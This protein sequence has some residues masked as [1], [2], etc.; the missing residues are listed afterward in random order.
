MVLVQNFFG[1]DE[2]QV[3]LGEAAPGQL[4]HPLQVGPRHRRLAGVRVHA[5]QLLEV[6]LDLNEGLVWHLHLGELFAEGRDFLG[7][8]RALAQLLLDGLELLAEVVLPLALVHLATGVHGDL[9]LDLQQLDLPHEQ[10]VDPLEAEARV[11]D[12][13]DLLGLLQLEVQVGGHQVRQAARVVEVAGDDQDLLGQGLA[14]GHG[15]FQGLLDAAQEGV[16]LQVRGLQLRLSQGL[17][18]GLEEVLG[19]GE[20]LHPHP[21]K[22]LHQGPDATVRQLQDPHDQGGGAHLV[23]VRGLGVVHLHLL[24]REQQDHAVLHQGGVHGPDGLLPADAEGEDHIGVH[25]HVTE[26]QY[27]QLFR[28]LGLLI[29]RGGQENV[30][31]HGQTSG[32]QCSPTCADPSGGGP[33]GFPAGRGVGDGARRDPVLATGPGLAPWPSPGPSPCA[34]G[35]PGPSRSPAGP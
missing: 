20:V 22:T 13:Q 27:R 23:E 10:L 31:G 14:Q 35:P 21:L 9:L 17:H 34:L 30:V 16:L 15:L 7:Q 25:H 3:V 4:G 2:I 26:G 28:Q 18:P 33:P 29:G 6:A 19:L 11:S 12:L 8:L 5:L 1:L 32:V 24:L